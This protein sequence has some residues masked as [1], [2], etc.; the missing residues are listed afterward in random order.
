MPYDKN[1]LKFMY[2]LMYQKCVKRKKWFWK[3]HE[4]K[5]NKSQRSC[6]KRDLYQTKTEKHWELVHNNTTYYADAQFGRFFLFT[7]TPGWMWPLR[8]LVVFVGLQD[9]A[10]LGHHED[11]DEV[12]NSKSQKL[13]LLT[14]LLKQTSDTKGSVY[15]RVPF[16]KQW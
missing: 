13:S 1:T 16:L 10:V 12:N 11:W 7:C 15:P 6:S 4:M 3:G 5:S 14:V 8:V 9:V 2:Q